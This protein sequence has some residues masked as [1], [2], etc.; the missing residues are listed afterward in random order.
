[1]TPPVVLITGAS[2]G[3]GRAVAEHL[4]QRGCRVYGTSRR[5][6]RAIV[7]DRAAMDAATSAFR[8]IPMDVTSDDSVGAAIGVVLAREGRI[9]VVVNSAGSGIAGSVE[10]TSIDEARAQ[11]ETN[12]FGVVR[13]CRAVLPVMRR[14]GSGC[15]INVSSIAGR[16]AVPFQAFYTA[17]KFAVE[18]FTEAL[19]MEAAPFGVRVA[20][21]EP[22][23]FRTGFTASR[24]IVHAARGTTAYAG[25]QAAA[26]KVMEAD[27]ANGATPEVVGRLVERIVTTGAP[28]LRYP[29]GPISE[30]LALAL[31]RL[32]PARLFEWTIAK[33]Y[34][35]R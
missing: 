21:V 17:S 2:S 26:L 15:V 35:V 12:F 33:Y 7:E 8:L 29:V 19:R 23:D 32:A 16:I 4:H 3:I 11:F 25:R 6:P 22:G 20:L 18:G 30:R 31:R 10:D 14:Q 24:V 9:D 1:M 28:R 27:E 5:A 13:V 34:R